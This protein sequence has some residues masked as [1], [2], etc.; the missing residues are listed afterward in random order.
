MIFYTGGT[1]SSPAKSTII[2]YCDTGSTVALYS[3][4]NYTTLVKTTTERNGEWWFKNIG[5]GTYYI[6]ATHGSDI[7]ISTVN[8][9]QF[10]VYRVLM[11]YQIKPSSFIFYGTKGIDYEVYDDSMNVIAPANYATAT[12]WQI[13]FF[14]SGTI[15]IN[16]AGEIDVCGVG[17]GAS[18]SPGRTQWV[19]Y[20][21][22]NGGGGGDVVSVNNVAV[23]RGVFEIA[24]GQG[25]EAAAYGGE[26]TAGGATTAFGVTANGGTVGAGGQAGYG[27][28]PTAGEAGTY[29]FND[30][31][32]GEQF[33]ADGGAGGSRE[34]QNN[35]SGSATP[36]G[37]YGAGDGGSFG[38]NGED[39]VA[40]TGS[41]GGG[42]GGD[43]NGAAHSGAGAAGRVIIRNVRY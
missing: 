37:N 38:A 11:S 29:P 40:N 15:S 8:V 30:S 19:Y 27:S 26:A 21:G 36:G 24:I 23:S 5:E 35:G 18:G 7:A 10:D 20:N 32:F 1:S 6:R 9:T 14:A 13:H 3:D 31:G 4:A 12:N 43:T 39:A 2:V 33:G 17:G 16:G 42:G 34:Y 28:N 41:G 22:G 25:G